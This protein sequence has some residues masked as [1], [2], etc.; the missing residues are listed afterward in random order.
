MAPDPLHPA[1]VHFPVVL[2]VLLPVAGAAALVAI[3]RG[4][5]PWRA[6]VPVLALSAALTGSSWV[7]VETG[8]HEEERVEDIVPESA[9]ESHEESAELF[10]AMTVGALLLATG[11]LLRGRG[12]RVFRYATVL[13]GLVLLAQGIT[14]GHR[15]GE[16]VYVHGAAA[17]YVGSDGGGRGTPDDGREREHDQR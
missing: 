17:A 1:V 12:G 14:V 9:L 15:G 10:L 3:R 6:W 4:A 2:V 11:G 13:G 5:D 7:A 16:L 8:Q